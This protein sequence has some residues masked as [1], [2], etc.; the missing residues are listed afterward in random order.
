L[1]ELLNGMNSARIL[2]AVVYWGREYTPEKTTGDYTWIFQHKAEKKC[3]NKLICKNLKLGGVLNR[4]SPTKGITNYK[5]VPPKQTS[6]YDF[7]VVGTC[8]STFVK[9][10]QINGRKKAALQYEITRCNTRPPV[11]QRLDTKANTRLGTL[12]IFT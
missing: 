8:G 3:E 2:A 11:Q 9:T 5:L 4:C 10:E 7:Y 1:A 12:T 6:K